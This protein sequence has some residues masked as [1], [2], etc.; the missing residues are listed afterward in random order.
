M[1]N[2]SL[3]YPEWMIGDGESHRN[4]GEIFDWFAV[5][6][7]SEEPLT[8]TPRGSRSAIPCGDFQYR[9]TAEVVFVVEKKAIVIDFGLLAVSVLANVQPDVCIGD[10]VSGEIS[11]GLPLCIEPIPHDLITR[12]GRQWQVDG[13]S[14]DLTPYSDGR[15]DIAQ[16]AYKKVTSTEEAKAFDYVLHCK[17]LGPSTVAYPHDPS[18]GF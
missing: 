11:I 13:I 1:A 9:I 12:M 2:W 14:A 4:T 17:E 15:R 3:H 8:I 10:F 18:G 6:F 16:I 5:E 7:W